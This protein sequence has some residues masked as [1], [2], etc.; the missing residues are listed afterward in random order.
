MNFFEA[1]KTCLKKFI[2]FSGRAS[3]SEFWYFQLF[4]II[5]ILLYFFLF[6]LFLRTL[7]PIIDVTGIFIF[8]IPW[9]LIYVP[10]YAVAVR[11]LHDINKSGWWLIPIHI[12]SI[13]LIGSI[14]FIIWACKESVDRDNYY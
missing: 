3:R 4:V 10:F 14:W 1:T 5:Y 13:F 7:E 9:I 2:T 6:A 8:F 11:R 12:S